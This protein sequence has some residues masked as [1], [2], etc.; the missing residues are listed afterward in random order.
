MYFAKKHQIY[1]IEAFDLSSR[2]LD[3]L[4][5]MPIDNRYFDRLVQHIY[6]TELRLNKTHSSETNVK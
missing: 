4:V 2:Y 3:D 6:P 1:V 5:S